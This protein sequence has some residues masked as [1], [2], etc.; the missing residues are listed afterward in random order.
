MDN[1]YRFGTSIFDM[2]E[3]DRQIDEGIDDTIRPNT[4][5]WDL[6]DLSKRSK[7]KMRVLI[8]GRNAAN[9]RRV[10]PGEFVEMPLISGL[11]Y[12]PGQFD[13][14][15]DLKN[16]QVLNRWENQVNKER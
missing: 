5:W 9:S 16:P 14:L 6:V 12:E 1:A 4:A 7:L 13:Y 15:A 10:A 2:I 8:T 3:V 11:F